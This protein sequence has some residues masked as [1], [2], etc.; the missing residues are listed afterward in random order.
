MYRLESDSAI[1]IHP[2]LGSRSASKLLEIQLKVN[3]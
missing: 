3:L 2:F 1:D